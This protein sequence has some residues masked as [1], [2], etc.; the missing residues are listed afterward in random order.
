MENLKN[1]TNNG[2]LTLEE[3]NKLAPIVED[4]TKADF[5]FGLNLGNY[6]TKGISDF[7]RDLFKTSGDAIPQTYTVPILPV[8]TIQIICG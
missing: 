4:F 8:S 7:G 1:N 2:N 3:V 6:F 5:T